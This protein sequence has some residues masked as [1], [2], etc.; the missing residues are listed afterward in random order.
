[1]EQGTTLDRLG[2]SE[3]AEIL[4]VDWDLIAPDEGKR[5]RALGIDAGA[6]VSIAHRGIFGGRDPLAI[7]VGRTIVALRR[8]HARA[9]RIAPQ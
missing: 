5:L 1:M 3:T 2:K 9:M 4:S 8:S 6:T 7:E